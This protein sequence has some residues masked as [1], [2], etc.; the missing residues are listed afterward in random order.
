MKKKFLIIQKTFWRN[1]LWI[2][3]FLAILFLAIYVTITTQNNIGA[4]VSLCTTPIF[5][6]LFIVI[7]LMDG[8][9]ILKIDEN[10]IRIKNFFVKINNL[11]WSEINDVYIYQ[12]NGTNKIKIPYKRK[13]YGKFNI[14]GT[15]G[16]M[17]RKI[18]KKWIFVDDG[19]GDNGDNIFE[20]FI[21]LRKG[22]IIRLKYNDCIISTIKKYYKEE[23]IEKIIE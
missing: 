7:A 22:A 16:F 6:I 18:T 9:N 20:Y 14:G 5:I 19:R 21:P 15:I 13:K 10:G 1:L 4:I 12:F 17:P 3:V 23:I 2:C 11:S 8:M